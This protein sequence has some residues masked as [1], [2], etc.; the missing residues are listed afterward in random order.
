PGGHLFVSTINRTRRATLLAVWLAESIG[1]IPK[2]THDPAR[3]VRPDELIAFA[4][5][6]GLEPVAWQGEAVDVWS[7]LRERAIVLRRGS[8]LGVG[9][10]CWLRKEDES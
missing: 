4:E 5:S 2:G 10:C 7:T 3:F 8:S 1:L 6:A 9:Y